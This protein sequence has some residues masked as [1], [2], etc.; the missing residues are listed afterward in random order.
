MWANLF[1]PAESFGQQSVLTV[2]FIQFVKSISAARQDL[3]FA[4]VAGDTDCLLDGG[5]E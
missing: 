3:L 5:D 1:E 4:A 2:R